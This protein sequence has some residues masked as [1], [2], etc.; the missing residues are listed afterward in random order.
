MLWPPTMVAMSAANGTSPKPMMAIR[1]GMEMPRTRASVNT[2]RASR[3]ELQN[4]AS[5]S[6][7]CASSWPSASRPLCNEREAPTFTTDTGARPAR[8]TASANAVARRSARSSSARI[9]ARWRRPLAMRKRATSRP[10]SA[11]EN[12]T[13]MSI[14]VGV[15]SQVST[16]GMPDAMRRVR[17]RPGR[18]MPVRKIPSGRRP[19]IAS[20]SDSSRAAE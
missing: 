2:P 8:A 16:T 19:M 1:S 15:R 11:C 9:S 13:S 18:R 12:P 6:G 4:T 10:M 20:S 5:T 7:A 3:S 17:P 14:G